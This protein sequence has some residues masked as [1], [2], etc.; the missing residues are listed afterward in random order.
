MTSRLVVGLK[1][2]QARRV[3]QQ[4]SKHVL[5]MPFPPHQPLCSPPLL[6]LQSMMEQSYRFLDSEVDFSEK[7]TTLLLRAFQVS[8]MLGPTTVLAK[9]ACGLV[10]SS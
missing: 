5:F 3:S 6:W 4:A 8:H 2:Q 7:Q 10:T 1:E 9:P